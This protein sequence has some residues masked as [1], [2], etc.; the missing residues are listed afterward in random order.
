[1]QP[2]L[3]LAAASLAGAILA[4]APS[5]HAQ[6]VPGLKVEPCT[7][8]GIDGPARCGTLDVWENRTTRSGRKIPVRFV[9]LPTRGSTPAR[10]AVVSI[11]G[12]PGQ[13]AVD[14]AP[15]FGRELEPLR[16]TRD[17]LLI[18]HRGTGGS[19]LLNCGLYGTGDALGSYLG[20]FYPA[21]RV[22]VCA[23]EWEGKADL[24]QY[25]SDAAAD[26]MDEV[27][28]T[29]GYEKLNLIGGSFGT[30]GVL[31]YLRRH[32]EH[33]RVGVLN[34]T[35]P[36]D[37]R[38]VLT[39]ASDAQRA[40]DG[41]FA[42]CRAEAACNAAFPDLPGSLRRAVERLSAGP[43]DVPIMHPETG[44]PATMPL[45]RDLFVEAVRYLTYS[46]GNAAMA[47]VMVHQAANGD[48]GPIAEYAL[49]SRRNIVADGSDGLYLSLTCAE[50][51]AFFT[52]EE[53]R[54]AS[55]GTYIGD[56]RVRDQKAA[57]ASWPV[58]PVAAAARVPVRSGAPVLL[59]S[60]QWDP[61]TPPAHAEQ[62]MRTLSN[63]RHVVIP[64]GAHSPWGLQ[65]GPACVSRVTEA[66]I[67]AGDHRNLDVSCIQ[68]LRRPPFLT[69][70]LGG[71]P[72]ELPAER[73]ARFAGRYRPADEDFTVVVEMKDGVLKQVLPDGR[74]FQ[75]LPVSETRFR[76]AGAPFSSL[77]FVE[78]DGRVTGLEARDGG[79]PVNVLRRVP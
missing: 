40:L 70:K 20:P 6:A 60:G 71:M 15:Y 8:R 36:V 39:L 19:N 35:V 62:A 30:R 9:V 72:I 34:G 66:F 68:A 73:L 7:I 25:T 11:P 29:L 31:V 65:G 33:A 17:I 41:V 13:S 16:D 10:E 4:T 26:D 44:K 32:P 48:F 12:G 23:K 45:T 46:V 53:G 22:A 59:L 28:A 49:S 61:V 50:D 37:V 67:R 38:Y 63:A 78:T 74:E 47:P 27:R 57:C 56:Y 77:T 42:D 51:L 52:L 58:G 2:K 75:L 64:S 18:D 69:T 43:V 21:D 24:A 79:A 76:L 1:M 14:L 3:T 5:L 55:A 54:A